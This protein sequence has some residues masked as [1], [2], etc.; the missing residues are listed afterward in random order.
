MSSRLLNTPLHFR[1]SKELQDYNIQAESPNGR[2]LKY[3]CF[4]LFLSE[5]NVQG[6][7]CV[8]GK[9]KCMVKQ[10]FQR[11]NLFLIHFSPV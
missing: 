4:F 6:I 10:S 5:G 8:V 2:I 7:N 9:D 3:L 11:Q 1:V